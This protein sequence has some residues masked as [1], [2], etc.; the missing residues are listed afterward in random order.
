MRQ[1]T[2]HVAYIHGCN[3]VTVTPCSRQ[4]SSHHVSLIE[5]AASTHDSQRLVQIKQR[6]DALEGIMAGLQG[7]LLKIVELTQKP[8]GR[9]LREFHKNQVRVSKGRTSR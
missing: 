3:I 9:S 7:G 5:S 1:F 8:P 6:L 2:I 4:R